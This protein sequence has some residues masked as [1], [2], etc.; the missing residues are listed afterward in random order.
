M[1]RRI[2]P[3]RIAVYVVLGLALVP[4]L[5]PVYYAFAGAVMG[6]GDLATYPP[7]L[8]PHALHWQNFGDVFDAVPLGRFYVNSAVQAGVITLAQVVTS[9]LAAYAFAF[10]RMPAK[11]ATFALFLATLMVPWESII[12]PNY[13]AISDWGLAR[14]GLTYLGLVLPFL[15][16]AFGTFLLRQAFLQFPGELRDAAVIDGCGHWRLLWRVVVPLSKPS[17]AAVGVYVFLSAWNQYFWPLILIRDPEYQTLQIGISQLND[18]EAAQPGL[19]LA[20]VALSLLP[21]LAVVIFGQ[22][23]IVR[24]LTAGAL[25]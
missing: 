9:I 22:R 19:I 11:A 4:V 17:I 5:F 1:S 25:R 16:S 18:A 13:L 20:G 15:A 14:G 6:P 8:V 7:A 3:G 2:S 24:G 21:T 23:Y 10:L 12:I